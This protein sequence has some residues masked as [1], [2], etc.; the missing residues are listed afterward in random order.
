MTKIFKN[1]IL[2]FSIV[3]G[4]FYFSSCEKYTYIVDKRIPIIDTTG[5]DTASY[6]KFATEIQ[7]IFTAKCI[8][9]HKG[10]RNPDLR[11]GNSYASLTGGGYVNAPASSSKLYTQLNAG[12]HSSLTTQDD[13]TK[14]LLWISQGAKNN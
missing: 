9:C 1:L 8:G 14:I 13:K 11:E 3:A 7:P 10:T 4:L 5:N 12:S 6:V 2:L